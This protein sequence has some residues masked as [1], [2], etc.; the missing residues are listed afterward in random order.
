[1]FA[2]F[3]NTANREWWRTPDRESRGYLTQ[4]AAWGYLLSHVE[5][6]AAG[7]E[8]EGD[9]DHEDGEDAAAE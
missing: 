5:Q 8:P 6:L 9:A 3:E 1:M 7:I 2:G 4:L